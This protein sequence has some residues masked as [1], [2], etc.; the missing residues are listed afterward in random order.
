MTHKQII[1]QKIADSDIDKKYY[2]ST[3][4]FKNNQLAYD[5][6]AKLFDHLE[7]INIEEMEFLK[8]EEGESDTIENFKELINNLM[9]RYYNDNNSIYKKLKK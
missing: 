3:H 6:L 8:N 9:Y 4:Q 5:N 1:K 2:E 7:M